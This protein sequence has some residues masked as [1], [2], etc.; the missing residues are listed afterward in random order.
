MGFIQTL[1]DIASYLEDD[2]DPEKRGK[3]DYLQI[4]IWKVYQLLLEYCCA[5]DYKML[6]TK[7]QLDHDE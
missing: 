7:A 4:N 1:R 5:T 2:P 6:L 3:R